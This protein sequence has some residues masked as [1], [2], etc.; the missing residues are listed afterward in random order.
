[1]LAISKSIT[2]YFGSETRQQMFA[3]LHGRHVDTPCMGTNLAFHPKRCK[4]MSDI[5]ANNS[6]AEMATDLK[7]EKYS[8]IA[9]SF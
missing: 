3:L 1:M 4:F 2:N 5:Q 7:F 9:H 6:S 8:T